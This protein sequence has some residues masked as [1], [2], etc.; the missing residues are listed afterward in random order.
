MELPDN[1]LIKCI[2]FRLT[3]SGCASHSIQSVVLTGDI[4]NMPHRG[5]LSW[6]S[7]WGRVP[8]DQGKARNVDDFLLSQLC[9]N[10]IYAA[11]FTSGAPLKVQKESLLKIYKK[12][13]GELCQKPWLTNLVLTLLIQRFNAWRQLTLDLP[14]SE[15]GIPDEQ[16]THYSRSRSGQS[17]KR[18]K[19]KSAG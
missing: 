8:G 13:H 16:A 11:A 7:Y 2:W 18:L 9:L 12:I 15:S 6:Y 1:A 4:L 5:G 17:S 3:I 10:D 14:P 19:T